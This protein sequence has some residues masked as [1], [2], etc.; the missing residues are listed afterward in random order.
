MSKDTENV[1]IQTAQASA[2][3]RYPINENNEAFSIC[4]LGPEHGKL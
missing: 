4:K 1:Q 3:R 2:Q